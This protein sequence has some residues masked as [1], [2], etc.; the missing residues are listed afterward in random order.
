M[1]KHVFDISETATHD[2]VAEQLRALADQIAGGSVDLSYDEW[3]GPTAV[4]DPVDVVVDLKKH[5]H[6]VELRI[7]MRWHA[8]ETV[9]V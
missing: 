3:H 6:T 5:R 9:H 8:D 1:S 7:D 2:L 4:V